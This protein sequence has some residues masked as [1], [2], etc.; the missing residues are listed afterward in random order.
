MTCRFHYSEV[1]EPDVDT[2]KSFFAILRSL[3]KR[4]GA[5][6]N[7][8]VVAFAQALRVRNRRAWSE[9]LGILF[10]ASRGNLWSR[11]KNCG[12]SCL[13]QEPLKILDVFFFLRLNLS[14]TETTLREHWGRSCPVLL[15][16]RHLVC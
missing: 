9:V 1:H 7:R 16:T 6:L 5:R 12:E 2:P 10:F 4:L 14:E 8:T 15:A 3:D 11:K 13:R